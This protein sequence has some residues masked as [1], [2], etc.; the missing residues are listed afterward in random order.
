[1]DSL[2]TEIIQTIAFNTTLSPADVLSFSLTSKTLYTSI[3][4]TLHAENEYDRDQ[5][6]ACAGLVFCIKRKWWRGAR[7]ALNNAPPTPEEIFIA[8]NAAAAN[9]QIDLFT[10]LL[11]LPQADPSLRNNHLLLSAAINNAI[12]V[13]TLLLGDP[14]VGVETPN[15]HIR[16][17]HGERALQAAAQTGAIEAVAVLLDDPRIDPAFNSHIAIRHAAW[18]G[19]T[20]L[21]KMLLAD[22]RLDPAADSNYAIRFAAAHGHADVVSLLLADPRV[23]PTVRSNLPITRALENSQRRKTRLARKQCVN[24][25]KLLAQDPRVISAG[26][27]PIPNRPPYVPYTPPSSSSSSSSSAPSSSPS[28]TS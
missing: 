12:D 11:A 10:T 24:V 8:L 2:P 3:L 9:D 14:R 16:G 6:R 26:L 18:Y 19:H 27:P 7:M 21:T 13:L 1:M 15:L 4:G 22:P 23:D 28:H 20:E 5:H 25:V 17:N